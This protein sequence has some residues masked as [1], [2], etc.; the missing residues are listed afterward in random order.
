MERGPPPF[1]TPN[2][3]FCH[4]HASRAGG[5][6]TPQNM[7]FCCCNSG[8][9]FQ[10]PTFVGRLR[11]WGL[12]RSPLCSQMRLFDHDT[13]KTHM[14]WSLVFI[15]RGFYHS[16]FQRLSEFLVKT[17]SKWITKRQILE[18]SL[19]SVI[20]AMVL[21][22]F[23]ATGPKAL[24]RSIFWSLRDWF[25]RSFA[26]SSYENHAKSLYIVAIGYSMLVP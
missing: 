23:Y 5:S 18:I 1:T 10:P 24:P 13:G 21:F 20:L 8:L 16:D 7:F 3:H 14:C 25:F 22:S 17:N 2:A 15:N 19:F 4:K 12:L 26:L 11:T 6:V 9:H